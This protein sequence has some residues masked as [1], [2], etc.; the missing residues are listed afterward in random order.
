M[1]ALRLAR[2]ERDGEQQE[3]REVGGALAVVQD[4]VVPGVVEAEIREVPQRRMGVAD[5]VQEPDVR[6]DV[7]G[8]VPVPGA[9]LVLLRVE[10][11]LLARDRLGLAELEAVVHAPAAGQRL[12]QEGADAEAG[13]AAALQ[14]A[15]VDVEIGRESWGEGV[16]RYG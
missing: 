14:E 4:P 16:W 1:R 13:A 2:V 3:A 15:R 12:R 6:L 5:A 10:V 7:A 11:F 8:T 9:D